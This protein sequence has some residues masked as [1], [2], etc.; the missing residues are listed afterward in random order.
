MRDVACHGVDEQRIA[1]AL[2]DVEGRAFGYWYSATYGSSGLCGLQRMCLYLTEATGH[3]PRDWPSVTPRKPDATERASAAAELDAAAVSTPNQRPLR[4]LLE[5]D[6]R[7][8]EAALTDRLVRLSEDAPADAPV[9]SLLPLATISLAPLAVQLQ[10]WALGV[11][12]GYL[13]QGLVT[14]SEVRRNK[15]EGSG[16]GPE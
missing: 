9:R 8:L 10:G 15:A 11:T 16:A 7:L 13:P 2:E 5:G 3:L 6:R 12:S 14:G 1:P 4:V